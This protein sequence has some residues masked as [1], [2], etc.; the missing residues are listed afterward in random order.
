MIA[1]PISG[2][3]LTSTKIQ[4]ITTPHYFY[5]DGTSFYRVTEIVENLTPA[6]IY[7]EG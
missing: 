5:Y 6:N 4:F 3:G 1:G 2:I 7:G